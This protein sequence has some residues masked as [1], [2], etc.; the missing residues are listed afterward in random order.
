MMK[1][2][3]QRRLR[4]RHFSSGNHQAT[5]QEV[6]FASYVPSDY[7]EDLEPGR[8]EKAFYDPQNF[9]Y[10]AGTHIAEGGGG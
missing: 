10:P 7:P 5:I 9:T 2:G 6:A 4:G 8:P 1:H 3:R